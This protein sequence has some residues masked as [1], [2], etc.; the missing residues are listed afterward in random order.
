MARHDGFASSTPA[1]AATSTE[2]KVGVVLPDRSLIVDS[3]AVPSTV[4]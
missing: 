1:I 2:F 4:A 3:L